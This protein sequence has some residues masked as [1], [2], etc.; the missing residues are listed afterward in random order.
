MDKTFKHLI[1]ENTPDPNPHIMNGV[2]CYHMQF[3]EKYLD[4]ILTNLNKSWPQGLEYVGF[5]RCTPFEE[6]AEITNLKSKNSKRIYNLAKSNVYLVKYWFKYKGEFLKDMN[7]K[8]LPRYIMLPYE[9]ESGI[10]YLNGSCF[11]IS[12]VLTDNVLSP[13][14]NGLFVRLLRHKLNFER[15]YFN[16]TINGIRTVKHIPCGRLHEE[17]K[18]K[19]SVPKTTKCKTTVMHYLLGKYGFSKTFEK[20]GTCVPIIGTDDITSK[21][22]PPNEWV[23]FSSCGIKQKTC[24]DTNYIPSNIKVV[25]PKSKCDRTMTIMIS[26]FFYIVDHFTNR[27]KPQYVNNCE[28]WKVLLGHIISSGLYNDGKLHDEIVEHYNALDHYLD[29]IIIEKLALDGYKLDNFYDLLSVIIYKIDDLVIL[30]DNKKN[31]IFKKTLEILY[32]ILFDIFYGFFRTNFELN[33]IANK[34]KK[35]G[36]D[37]IEKEIITAM[38]KFMKPG[39]IHKLRDKNIAVSTVSDSGDHKYPKITSVLSQQQTVSGNKRN[40]GVRMSIKNI[41][42]VYSALGEIGSVLFLAKSSVNP[43]AKSNMFMSFDPL[44]GKIIAKEKFKELR[45]TTD[46]FLAKSFNFLSD[47]VDEEEDIEDE[48]QSEEFDED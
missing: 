25:V 18:N 32:Y 13:E 1:L 7:D 10:I 21:K 4:N 6:Y 23:I 37:L 30:D 46:S 9:N 5:E 36:K 41:N 16:I 14:Y 38:N 39:A 12:P 34:K 20:Y 17:K 24:L 42:S 43:L 47:V 35:E 3:V 48:T 45:E 15:H 8:P 22:Y 40:S 31:I 44:H 28:L 29:D 19:D 27:I 2:A 26:S 11:H 33:R